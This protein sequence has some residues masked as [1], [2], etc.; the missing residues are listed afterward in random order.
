[1][2]K[3]IKKIYQTIWEKKLVVINF[4]KPFIWKSE[5]ISP[6]YIDLRKCFSSY[7]FY[8][9]IIKE[10]KKL[11][12]KN[13]TPDYFLG[14]ATAGI[15]YAAIIGHSLK[16]PHGYGKKE[17]KGYGKNKLIEG[18]L[19][20]CKNIVL[21]DDVCSTGSSLLKTY[22]FI[23]KKEF[24]KGAFYVFSYQI[25]ESFTN[26]ENYKIP[27]F[28]LLNIKDLLKYGVKNNFINKDIQKKV[29]KFTKNF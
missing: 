16:L 11:I 4:E 14:I 21:I 9:I 26:F 5:K 13:T 15:S 25:P 6:I 18:D 7:D 1:M 17:P 20:N 12:L 8:Q 24:V 23:E 28:Y 19:K 27:F 2:N 22:E 3:D 29:I 10:L